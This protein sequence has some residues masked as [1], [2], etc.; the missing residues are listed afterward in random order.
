MSDAEIAAI[1]AGVAW[2]TEPPVVVLRIAGDDAFTV[3]DRACA[4]DL[5][6]RDG[7][8]RPTVLLD[9][10]ARV[11]ADVYVGQDDE[12]YLLFAEGP[13]AEQLTLHLRAAAPPGARFSI[14]ELT[15]EHDTLSVH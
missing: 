11:F 8:V 10:H 12:A 3:M 5:F 1:R 2:S 9:E 7:Q 15:R 13:S 4:A 6:V 14:E